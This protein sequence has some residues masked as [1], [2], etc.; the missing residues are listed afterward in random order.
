MFIH[1]ASYQGALPAPVLQ[2]AFSPSQNL[3]AWTDLEGNFTR[4]P[5]PIPASAPDPVKSSAASSV[6]GVQKKRGKTPTLFDEEADKEI[7]KKDVGDDVD[8]DEELAVALDDDNWIMDDLGVGMDDDAEE[9]RWSAKEGVK[10]MGRFNAPCSQQRLSCTQSVSLRHSPHSSLDQHPCRP[11]S[12]T[13][14]GTA[15]SQY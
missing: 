13:L 6:T 4:W 10:E 15:L 11:K 9:K 12:V 8:M 2:L 5:E 3:L 1:D 7:A 14:V